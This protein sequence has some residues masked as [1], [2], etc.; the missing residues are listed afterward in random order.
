MGLHYA[1]GL[2]GREV[3]K[4]D[5]DTLSAYADAGEQG[6]PE[7]MAGRMDVASERM[8]VLAWTGRNEFADR[9][10]ALGAR[11]AVF[12]ELRDV[13]D[14]VSS[15][16]LAE[17]DGCRDAGAAGERDGAEAGTALEGTDVVG[18][19]FGSREEVDLESSL[20]VDHALDQLLSSLSDDMATV[21]EVRCQ[22]IE[23]PQTNRGD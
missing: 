21:L 2:E 18:W 20:E 13:A 6:C 22:E 15:A 17:E 9:V 11:L 23:G 3:V 5:D 19:G 1:V 4:A 10:A 8:S 7:R 14:M 16:E 12:E